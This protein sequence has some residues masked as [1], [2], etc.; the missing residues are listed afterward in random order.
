MEKELVDIKKSII[1][2]E[3][4]LQTISSSLELDDKEL[5]RTLTIIKSSSIRYFGWILFQWILSAVAIVL[6]RIYW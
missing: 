6:V 2:I 3:D 4:E 5:K 1:R